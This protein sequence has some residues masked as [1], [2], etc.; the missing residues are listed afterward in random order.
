MYA[1]TR[2]N[3]YEEVLSLRRSGGGIGRV[4]GEGEG[5]NA[6]NIVFMYEIQQKL[7]VQIE[8]ENIKET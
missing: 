4:G 6:I 3:N 7:K 2:H 1:H 5:W 8:K